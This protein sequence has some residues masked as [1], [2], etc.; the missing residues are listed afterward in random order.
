MLS[1]ISYIFFCFS[2]HFKI[3]LLAV[4]YS[5]SIS[6]KHV[7]CIL[8]HA[9][10]GGMGGEGVVTNVTFG[11]L[12]FSPAVQQIQLMTPLVF[13]VRVFLTLDLGCQIRMICRL[14]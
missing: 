6:N 8:K 11:C 3:D 14:H 10:R 7:G 4:R 9:Q 13:L 2:L 5:T 12:R 1:C